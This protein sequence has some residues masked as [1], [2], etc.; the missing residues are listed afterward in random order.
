MPPE[1]SGLVV[2]EAE[3]D[4]PLEV[5]SGIENDQMV[6]YGSVPHSRW[7][8]GFLPPVHMSKLRLEWVEI[9]DGE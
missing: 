4:V 2:T 1:D 5:L 3:I 7:E 9:Q 8:A 6:F